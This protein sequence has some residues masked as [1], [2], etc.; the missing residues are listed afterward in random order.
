MLQAPLT[1]AILGFSRSRVDRRFLSLH[2]LRW[3]LV[4]V[5]MLVGTAQTL[6]YA[7]VRT[8]ILKLRLYDLTDSP[9]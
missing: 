9:D 5:E 6:I 2:W 8:W 1:N 4:I 7:K 3:T